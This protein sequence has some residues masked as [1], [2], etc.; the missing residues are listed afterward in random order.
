MNRLSAELCAYFGNDI[1]AMCF[2]D[3]EFLHRK[4]PRTMSICRGR[5][6]QVLTR[7]FT[8]HP[9]LADYQ[10]LNIQQIPQRALLVATEVLGPD[11]TL[12]EEQIMQKS[13]LHLLMAVQMIV[14]WLIDDTLDV[15]ASIDPEVARSIIDYYLGLLQS[16]RCDPR[17]AQRL[18]AACVQ[19][20]IPASFPEAVRLLGTWQR[21][22]VDAVFSPGVSSLYHRMNEEFMRAYLHVHDRF[23]SPE[24]YFRHRAANCGLCL[25]I[26]CG[27]SWFCRLRG[28][29]TAELDRRQAYFTTLIYQNSLL[30]GLN[31]DI[32]GYD[33]DV[34]EG[35][36][37]SVAIVKHHQTTAHTDGSDE[38]ATLHAFMW[39]IEYYNTMLARLIERG[40]ACTDLVEEAVSWASLTTTWAICVLQQE[41]M[42]I[43]KPGSFQSALAQLGHRP[44]LDPSILGAEAA[45]G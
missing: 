24:G 25:A 34:K 1:A 13:T 30:G 14:E 18:Q 45:A 15:D 6:L 23:D 43:Y 26:L 21:E 20:G 3:P 11:H 37:T 33:K 31:N 44:E 7:F 2:I 17:E 39:L 29:D 10:L 19:N 5:S 41:Y 4:L 38:Q 28:L 27:T 16:G 36:A 40:G 8:E 42:E 12:T 32:F 9:L 35:V 22:L